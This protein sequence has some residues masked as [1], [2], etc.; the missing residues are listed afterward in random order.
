MGGGDYRDGCQS[1]EAVK[2]RK[3]LTRG[4]S[5]EYSYSTAERTEWLALPRMA[6]KSY[7]WKSSQSGEGLMPLLLLE[8]PKEKR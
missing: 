6:P 3:V 4:T 1:K 7:D 2:V 5:V 8:I